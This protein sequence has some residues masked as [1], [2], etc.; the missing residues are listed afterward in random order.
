MTRMLLAVAV[1]VALGS[2]RAEACLEAHGSH[3]NPKVAQGLQTVADALCALDNQTARFAGTIR[4]GIV[5]TQ[6]KIEVHRLMVEAVPDA[7]LAQ[8]AEAYAA[9]VLEPGTA[10]VW[11][12]YYPVR[13][14]GEVP[15]W[16]VYLVG[17][18]GK[19]VQQ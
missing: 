18:N 15:A 8:G 9:W 19:A 1:T 12:V 13:L 3:P 17:P 10:G 4:V 2:G 16:R 6:L 14:A 11:V 5:G 7:A